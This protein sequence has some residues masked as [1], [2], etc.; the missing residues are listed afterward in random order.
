MLCESTR[1]ARGVGLNHLCDAMRAWK[2][3][4]SLF[5]KLFLSTEENDVAEAQSALFVLTLQDRIESEHRLSL[6]KN[7]SKCNGQFNS[8]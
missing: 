7:K 2:N 8:A 4:M 5:D 3:N 1:G 6:Q